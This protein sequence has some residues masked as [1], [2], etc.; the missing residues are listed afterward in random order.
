VPRFQN[1]ARLLRKLNAKL[2][3][4]PLRVSTYPKSKFALKIISQIARNVK[5]VNLKNSKKKKIQIA[6]NV[7][8]VNLIN[9]KNFLKGIKN[10][11]N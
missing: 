11:C 2:I 5:N 4:I 7:K 8:N 3:L 1:P 9:S 6:R 10:I